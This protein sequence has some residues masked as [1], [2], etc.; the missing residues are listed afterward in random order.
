VTS[1][2]HLDQALHGYAD[3]HQ[4][5]ASSLDLA[6]NQQSL[7]LIMSDLSGPAFR[8][9]Y[10]SYLTGYPLPG[11]GFYCFARTWFAPELPRPGCVWTHTL[12]IRDEDVARIADFRALKTMFRKPTGDHRFDIYESQSIFEEQ[13]H[14]R[15]NNRNDGRGVLRALYASP[16]KIVIPS[17]SS[18]PLE[19]LVLAI[20]DQQW[21]RLRRNFRFCTGSLS[22]R[23]NEFDL[24]ISPPEVTHSIGEAGLVIRDG[25]FD[26]RIS[27]P[28]LEC[29][30]DDLY[31]PARTPYREFLW[32]FGPDHAN[33]RSAFQPLT[34]TFLLV[35]SPGA[36]PVADST[37]SAIAHYFPQNH[38]ARRLK[39]ALFGKSG[40]YAEQ[41]GGEA[42]IM[43]LLVSH[44]AAASISEEM[45]SI[46][47]R[48]G[49]LSSRDLSAATD[50][51]LLSAQ[52][53]GENSKRFLDGF[54]ERGQWSEEL[55][56]RAPQTLVP[57]ILNHNPSLIGS[58][59]LWARSDHMSIL[60]EFV[61]RIERDPELLKNAITAIMD[62]G[63]WEALAWF[64][65]H[66]GSSALAHV[67]SR[68][69][70]S[71]SLC[72]DVP[73]SLFTMLVTRLWRSSELLSG[74]IVGPRCLKMLS[75]QLDPRSLYVRKV[76]S[77][78][79]LEA[80]KL[81]VD[82]ADEGR[83]RRS[84]IFFL[85]EGLRSWEKVGAELVASSFS[86]VYVAAKDNL[87]D[88]SLWEQLEPQLSW[89]R[90][91]WDRCA[92]LLRT[93]AKAFK[94]R[95]WPLNFFC[96]TFRSDEQLRRAVAE[97]AQMWGGSRF[98]RHLKATAQNGEISGTQQQLAILAGIEP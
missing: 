76:S 83:L 12:L 31:G 30:N 4:L 77:S 56:E 85:S 3:G 41:L 1:T 91:S 74:E 20:M 87:L 26:N 68:I 16:Q 34:E 44:P 88:S 7:M 92:R 81:Q 52:I 14:A 55:I 17:E 13:D 96:A 64:M 59:A 93:V 70:A 80:A 54:F 37:L 5:L 21:P 97:I 86:T 72:L 84:A 57:L 27:E 11:A 95:P 35:H 36:A 43:R 22:L 28:W 69:E 32:C 23:E 60:A 40:K 79:W 38:E 19:D 24:S 61:S 50:I 15:L 49:E 73:E 39:A 82:F 8:N 90:P 62:A 67:F 94:E 10:D 75:A 63:A 53:G 58:P 48:A 33:G 6:K 18:E 47:E 29:A 46:H 25:S 65:D 89:Y 71:Q 51:A 45:A 42:T 78:K 9:G 66:F 98:L 2:L